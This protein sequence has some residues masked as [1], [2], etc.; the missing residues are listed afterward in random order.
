MKKN[1]SLMYA[2]LGGVVTCFVCV[3]MVFLYPSKETKNLKGNSSASYNQGYY[4]EEI[5]LGD[6][7]GTCKSNGSGEGDCQTYSCSSFGE[8]QCKQNSACCKWEVA[9]TA[10]PSP[11]P[12]PTPTPTATTT[13]TPHVSSG[14]CTNGMTLERYH[15][16]TVYSGKQCKISGMGSFQTS[17]SITCGISSC[18]IECSNVATASPT[19]SPTPSCTYADKAACEAAN[20]G[21]DCWLSSGC[22]VLKTCSQYAPYDCPT[23]ICQKTSSACTEK[24]ASPTPT[25]TPMVCTT[26]Y[27]YYNGTECIYCPAGYKASVAVPQCHMVIPAGS[28]L[29]GGTTQ[30]L[31]CAAGSYSAGGTYYLNGGDGNLTRCTGC[32]SGKTSPV[33][34]KSVS[35]CY[36]KTDPTDCAVTVTTSANRVSYG[37]HFNAHVEVHGKGCNGQTMSVGVTRG[38]LPSSNRGTYNVSD[39]SAFNFTVTVSQQP[40]CKSTTTFS[41]SLS[42]GGKSGS[43]TVNTIV[44]WHLVST[45]VCATDAQIGSLTSRKAAEDAPA[46]VY[47]IVKNNTKCSGSKQVDIWRRGCGGGGTPEKIPYCYIDND[48]EYHW[49]TDPQSSWKKVDSI[50]SESNCKKDE[51]PACYTDKDGKY[52]WGKYATSDGYTLITSIKDEASCKEPTS[53]YACYKNDE[54]DYRW[55][56]TAPEGYTKVE[57]VKTPA[58]C[59][60]PEVPACYVHGSEFVW[61]KYAKI[62]GYIKLEDVEKEED[63]KLPEGDACYENKDGEYVW[64][65]YGND[66]D[67]TLVPSVTELSQCTKDV[68]TPPTATSVSKIVYVF[69]AVLMACGIGFIYYSSVMKKSDQQQ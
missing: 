47:Y 30:I 23:S 66:P 52:V 36:D 55:T 37:S 11:T 33:G 43:V 49:T 1:N 35:D 48:G 19:P 59:A 40:S 29:V 51:D 15:Y 39:G 28:Y 68:P 65:K 53:E 18:S 12:T 26:P 62:T 24:P 34:S 67:Y 6:D 32:P 4:D 61:G 2:I 44:D 56:T 54:G 5:S 27:T 63:C 41:A 50:T 25:P 31:S 20:P 10:S 9:A 57:E 3:G 22:Y 64:G 69:M 7:A 13:A 8:T 42:G 58:E 60:P 46:D 17:G 14:T 38:T 21:R 45:D 16:C